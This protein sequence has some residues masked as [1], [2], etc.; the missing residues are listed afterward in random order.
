[1]QNTVSRKLTY[2][3]FFFSLMIANYHWNTYNSQFEDLFFSYRVLSD[4]SKYFGSLAMAY[5]FFISGYLLYRNSSIDNWM[6]KIKNR[7]WSLLIPCMLWNF[8]TFFLVYWKTPFTVVSLRE[9]IKGI[10]IE[11]FDG[12]LWY[13]IAVFSLLAFLPFCVR[14]RWLLLIVAL[15]G[16]YLFQPLLGKV[17]WAGNLIYYLPAYCIGGFIGSYHKKETVFRIQQIISIVLFLVF[18]ILYLVCHA[19][20][21][22]KKWIILASPVVIWGIIPD[23]VFK[24]DPPFAVSIS[25][26][27]YA[28]HAGRVIP[29]VRKTILPHL[30]IMTS[31]GSALVLQRALLILLT[32]L[33]IYCL[34]VILKCILPNKLF[35]LLSGGRI[36]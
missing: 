11:P 29:F 27:I 13:M 34:T 3:S 8:I 25:F 14:C 1:M 12:P 31:S 15:Y 32:Y 35:S 30:V 20:G 2:Y 21:D 26:F 19:A 5:Y 4:I 9:F 18:S 22:L 17:A 10:A 36:Q 33:I 16:H 23:S 28:M 24:K 7:V 6:T